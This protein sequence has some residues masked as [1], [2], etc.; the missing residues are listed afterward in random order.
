MVS[1]NTPTTVV[2]YSTHPLPTRNETHHRSLNVRE[3][4]ET[5]KYRSLDLRLLDVDIQSGTAAHRPHDLGP[6]HVRDG[7]AL[8]ALPRY[9]PHGDGQGELGVEPGGP[10]ELL[11]EG[12]VRL[13]GLFLC[14][15]RRP[16]HLLLDRL[17]AQPADPYAVEELLD[18]FDVPRSAVLG[19]PAALALHA[20]HVATVRLLLQLLHDLVGVHD[21]H[22]R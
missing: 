7:P 11:A 22:V 6:R 8:G 12:H 15:R 9:I 3:A 19:D 13:Q 4:D 16:L 5:W 14:D 20:L 17:R 21:R 10:V 1:R 18:P 2:Y